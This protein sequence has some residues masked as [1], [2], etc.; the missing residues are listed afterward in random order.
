MFSGLCHRYLIEA[1]S[2]CLHPKVML[3]S[4]FFAFSQSLLRSTKYHVRILARLCLWDSRT[5]LGS[6]LAKIGRECGSAVNELTTA[7]IKANMRYFPI[8][9][10][11]EWRTGLLSELLCSTLELPGFTEEETSAMVSYLCMS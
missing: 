5:R 2:G 1:I 11:E 8:P 10:Q 4:R 6:T 9:S 3:A 7:M